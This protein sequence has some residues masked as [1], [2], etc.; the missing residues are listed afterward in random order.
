MVYCFE[1]GTNNYGSEAKIFL[2]DCVR[3]C[4]KSHEFAEKHVLIE[5]RFITY[6]KSRYGEDGVKIK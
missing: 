1:V 3:F 2:F 6:F 4:W 5:P